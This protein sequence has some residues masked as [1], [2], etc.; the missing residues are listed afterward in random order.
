MVL[1]LLSGYLT[2]HFEER[3]LSRAGPFWERLSF[4]DLEGLYGA[5]EKIGAKICSGL[6]AVVMVVEGGS[7]GWLLLLAFMVALFLLEG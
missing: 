5:L 3:L 6:R 2:F 1:P 4:L 7:L